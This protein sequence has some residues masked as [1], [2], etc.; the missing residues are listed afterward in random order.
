MVSNLAEDSQGRIYIVHRGRHPLFRLSPN[1]KFSES[2]GD[3]SITPSINYDL[4]QSPP[5][6]I[7]EAYWL[8]GLH[9]D[10]WDNIWTT[11]LGRHLI[12]KFSP[13]GQLL[14]T[15][16]CAD[17]PGEEL[18]RFN[19]PTAVVVGSLGY[20]Y[21]ADGYGNSRIVK[22]SPEGK[23]LLSWGKKGIGPGEFQTPHAIALDGDEN[24][25]VAE[26]MNNRV[27]IFDS[28]GHHLAVTMQWKKSHRW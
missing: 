2:I 14:L 9:I 26:R 11:D 7:S 16:G 4:T 28:Q 1:G 8:H 6:P 27:Q 17:L 10:P 12:L 22:Y 24:V 18:D 23:P 13:S 21:V 3:D 19:Q 25:F 20:I 5:S 15:L